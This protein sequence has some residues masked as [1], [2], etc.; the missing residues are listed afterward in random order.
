[1]RGYC[2]RLM[3]IVYYVCASKAGNPSPPADEPPV[4][5]S[6]AKKAKSGYEKVAK[7]KPD[8]EGLKL[9]EEAQAALTAKDFAKAKEL[10]EKAQAL[11]EASEAKA[12]KAPKVGASKTSHTT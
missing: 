3:S 6:G 9:G 8:P 1:M 7:K 11:C 12:V 2:D 10:F 5:M 4:S